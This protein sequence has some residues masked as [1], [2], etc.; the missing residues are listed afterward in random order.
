VYHG[1]LGEY[2]VDRVEVPPL[3]DLFANTMDDTL[4]LL[5]CRR[6][7]DRVGTT[8]R[9]EKRRRLRSRSGSCWDRYSFEPGG[10][11]TVWDRV[12]DSTDARVQRSVDRR[13]RC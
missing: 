8:I 13:E 5:G 1:V 12:A 3:L 10:S 4:V 2:L 6:R 7:V 11:P 9:E